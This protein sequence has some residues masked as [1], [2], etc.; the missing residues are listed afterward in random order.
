[1]YDIVHMRHWQFPLD[2]R[3]EEAA[4][5]HRGVKT[6]AEARDLRFVSGDLVVYSGT[7]KIVPDDEWLWDWEKNSPQS[8]AQRG[9]LH[10][11]SQVHHQ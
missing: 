5:I 10:E 4:I 7:M 6:L 9:I 11:M 2:L 3:Q 1:M 8:Y